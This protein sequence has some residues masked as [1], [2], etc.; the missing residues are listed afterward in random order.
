MTWVILW[1]IVVEIDKERIT[2][3][4]ESKRLINAARIELITLNKSL[5]SPDTLIRPWYYDTK[6]QREIHR[7]DVEWKKERE[8]LEGQ[9]ENINK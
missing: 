8:K 4:A 9:S 5:G 3:V 6:K 7:S 2:D 1:D